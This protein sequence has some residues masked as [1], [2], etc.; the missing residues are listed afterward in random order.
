MCVL[1]TSFL[2][3]PLLTDRDRPEP[4]LHCTQTFFPFLGWNSCI[5]FPPISTEPQRWIHRWRIH[6]CQN[7]PAL[8]RLA[9]AVS[10]LATHAWFDL[11]IYYMLCIFL[12]FVYRF[13]TNVPACIKRAAK[14]LGPM[15]HERL[16]KE[17]EYGTSDWP[18]KPV[19]T[20]SYSFPSLSFNWSVEWSHLLV[21][22]R[23]TR[24]TPQWRYCI[25]HRL[26]CAACEFRCHSY[27]GMSRDCFCI[28]FGF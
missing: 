24:W 8:P 3:N 2:W 22:G 20:H 4:G 17:E 13:L 23:S 6:G 1:P 10:S 25:Q 21:V 14:H 28:G 7:P 19:C 12:S 26:P 5:I 15:I 11:L 18:D 16:Q 27:Y 9:Q